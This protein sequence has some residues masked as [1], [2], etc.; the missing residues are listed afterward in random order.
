MSDSGEITN[1]FQGPDP[2]TGERYP[3]DRH[4]RSEHGM[5][6]QVHRLD[7]YEDARRKDTLV[8]KDVPALAVWIPRE[9]AADWIVQDR[10]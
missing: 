1:L 8:M 9:M 7:I 5:T 10:Q 4:V 3:G 2:E 6:I